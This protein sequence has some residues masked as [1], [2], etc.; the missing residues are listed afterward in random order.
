MEATI[1]QSNL[2]EEFETDLDNNEIVEIVENA[3]EENN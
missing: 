3:E 2:D 1:E